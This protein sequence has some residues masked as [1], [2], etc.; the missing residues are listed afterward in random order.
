MGDDGDPDDFPDPED[1][2]ESGEGDW[3]DEEGDDID[4]YVMTIMSERM[5]PVTVRGQSLSAVRVNRTP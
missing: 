2:E 4:T 5:L 3:D 1:D